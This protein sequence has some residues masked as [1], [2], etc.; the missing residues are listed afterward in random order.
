LTALTEGDGTASITLK[1]NGATDVVIP[2][3]W[4]ASAALPSVADIA[5]LKASAEYNAFMLQ[6]EPIVVGFING[7]AILQDAS[8]AIPVTDQLGSYAGYSSLKVG[9]KLKKVYSYMTDSDGD[10]EIFP[11]ADMAGAPVVVSSGN[12][13]EPIA[14]IASELDKF[15]PAYVKLTNV[16]FPSGT[17]AA[18][19]VTVKQN[20]VSFKIDVADGDL[21]GQN[22]PATSDVTGLVGYI[23]FTGVV[24]KIS[25]QADVPSLVPTGLEETASVKRKA[26]KFIRNGQLIIVRDGKMLNVLGAEL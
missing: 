12:A 19:T 24:L 3:S 26:E 6:T 17:F 7:V 4:S 14:T 13:L 9:D 25:S 18:G 23:S 20:G 11:S 1:S 15:G 2:V 21:V 8:G 10:I 22:M 16:E 5:A